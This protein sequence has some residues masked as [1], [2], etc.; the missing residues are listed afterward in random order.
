MASLTLKKAQFYGFLNTPNLWKSENP[1]DKPILELSN[2]AKFNKLSISKKLRLG[3]VV[4]QFVIH[5]LKQESNTNVI[6]EGL[7]IQDQKT[8]IGELDC[9]YLKNK[10]PIHLEIVYKFYLYDATLGNS[11]LEHWIGPNRND[12][13]IKKLQKLKTKQF[14]L[15]HNVKTKSYIQDL[16]LNIM[17]VKQEL[18][19]KAQLFIPFNSDIPHLKQLNPECINGFYIHYSKIDSFKSCK[20]YIPEKM[21]WLMDIPI[22]IDW[23]NFNAFSKAIIPY[24]KSES[25]P[26]CWIKKPNGETLKCFIVWW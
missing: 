6:A 17:D 8:T 20:F 1:L 7:Q 15:L 22:Q 14:P 25:A 18:C 23:L 26:L 13:L 10:T 3:K 21:D 9:L 5:C 24:I 16:G 2:T 19:F 11:E 12:S 4:E